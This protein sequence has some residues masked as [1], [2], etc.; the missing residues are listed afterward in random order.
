M[1][2]EFGSVLKLKNQPI[3]VSVLNRPEMVLVYQRLSG[4]LLDFYW[5]GDSCPSQTAVSIRVFTQVLLVVILGVV[6]RLVSGNF[7][8][9]RSKA[10]VRQF[11]KEATTKTQNVWI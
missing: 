5:T 6:E 3:I 4:L 10:V 8:C 1:K 11:L 2:F 9:D 7:C